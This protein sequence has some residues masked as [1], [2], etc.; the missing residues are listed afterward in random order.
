MFVR[1]STIVYHVFICVK[2]RQFLF[3]TDTRNKM[4]DFMSNGF[5]FI[6]SSGLCREHVPQ[7]VQDYMKASSG[8]LL[9]SKY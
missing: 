1:N 8:W 6:I 7:T 3:G 2:V 4:A 9:H 5:C